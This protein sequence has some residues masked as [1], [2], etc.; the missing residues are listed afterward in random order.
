MGFNEDTEKAKI[1]DRAALVAGAVED[2]PKDD[3]NSNSNSKTINW[4]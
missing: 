4:A 2:P 1:G 3:F